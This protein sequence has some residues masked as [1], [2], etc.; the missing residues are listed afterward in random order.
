MR[1]RF[2]QTLASNGVPVD[3]CSPAFPFTVTYLRPLSAEEQAHAAAVVAAFDPSDVAQQQ[4][5]QQRENAAAVAAIASRDAVARAARAGTLALMFSLQECRAKV[6]QLV[7]WANA[8]GASIPL[9]ETG[10]TVEEAFEQVAQ[11]IASGGVP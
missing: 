1:E 5:E 11:L 10:T 4:W 3:T 9:L 6:N 2:I 8:Q 7:T